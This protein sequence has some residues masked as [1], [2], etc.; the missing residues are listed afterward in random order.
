VVILFTITLFLSSSLLFLVQP[1]IGKMVLP[2]LGGTP[3]VWNTCMVFFQ[4]TLLAGYLY[5]HASTRWLRLQQQALVH[6]TLL[7]ISFLTLPIA[8]AA[9]NDPP[10]DGTPVLWL[11]RVLVL[12][13]GIPFFLVSTSGPLLQ[14]WFA[15]TDH[16]SASDPYFLSVAGNVGSIVALVAYP[17]LLEPSLR[18]GEQSSLWTTGYAILVLLTVACYW[19]VYRQARLHGAADH[20]SRPLTELRTES[21]GWRQRLHW[22]VLSFVPSS[23]LLGVTT[24]LTTDVAAVPLFWIVPLAIYLLTFALVFAKRALVPHGAAVRALPILVLP[25]ASLIIFDSELPAALQSPVHLVTFFLAAMVCH[26]ELARRR[27]HAR[28]LTEFYLCMSIGGVLGG[29]FNAIAAP[30]LFTTVLEYPLALVLA[31]ALRP[32]R[33]KTEDTPVARKLD[34]ALPLAFG[35]FVLAVMFAFKGADSKAPLALIVV[36]VVPAV[37]C[38]TFRPRPVRFALSVG[39][40]M[41]ASGA[42]MSANEGVSHRGRSFFG[43]H[44]ILNNSE[45]N[46]RYLVHGGI[47]HGVQSLDPSRR[48]KP[49]TYF[50][51]TGPIG[52]AFASFRGAT[53]KRR[54]GVVG[55]GVGTLAAY[56]EAGQDWTFYEIDPA[57]A[58]LSMNLGQFTYIA[59][60][61]A[62]MRVVLGDARMS[63]AKEPSHSFDLLVVDAF[64]S[65]AIP[66]H[67]VTREA[68]KLYWDKLDSDGVLAFHISNRYIDF[69]P[70]LSDLARDADLVCL[71]QNDLLLDAADKAD[72]KTPS[73]WA[74]MA[75]A[76]HD[77]GTLAHD[78]R[79]HTV[80]ARSRPL[81]WTDDFSNPLGLFRWFGK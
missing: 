75:R 23:L 52:Q 25:L 64:S 58:D 24:Y 69:A 18:L 29:L 47:I 33:K 31:C 11:L 71:V 65:D 19:Q 79:W 5:V 34:F 43:V 17:A 67:L 35:L 53:A 51:E 28:Y 63:L 2:L 66:V 68:L 1:M 70:L 26:G 76:Q 54:V 37:I 9:E 73:Q 12:T 48:R 10:V 7:V 22:I 77:L 36:Y 16:A 3:A 60:S 80:P 32:H 8:I 40:L 62:R 6:V 61:P 41:L 42:Y 4:A 55:L 20:P 72:E 57:I 59:D 74:I 81:A 56:S 27:P 44:R 30:L 45:R 14:R 21:P 15:R 13:V 39:A 38:F 50:H 49:S 46:A 78:S